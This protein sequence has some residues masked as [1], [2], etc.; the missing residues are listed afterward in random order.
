MVDARNSSATAPARP[1][2][3][4]TELLTRWM[5]AR[6]R[7]ETAQLGSEEFRQAVIEVGELEVMMNALDVAASGEQQAEPADAAERT[8]S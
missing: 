4:R 8:H 5:A 2:P 1:A 7:R 3:T 6:R